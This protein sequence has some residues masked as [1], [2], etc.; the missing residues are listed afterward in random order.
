ML[1]NIQLTSTVKGIIISF[2]SED[3]EMSAEAHGVLSRLV[4]V[5]VTAAALYWLTCF[6][7]LDGQKH[8]FAMSYN[9]KLRV[10]FIGILDR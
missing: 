10:D 2:A 4:S 5:Y 1:Y 3:I 9:T 8:T 7:I 6:D